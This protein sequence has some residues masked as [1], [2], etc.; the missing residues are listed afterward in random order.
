[1][2]E[3]VIPEFDKAAFNCPRCGAF[4]NQEWFLALAIDK[5]KAEYQNVT[6][7]M[8]TIDEYA[9]SKCVHCQKVSIWNR[10]KSS[11][12]YPKSNNRVFDL[13]EV[14]KDLSEDY[15]EACLVLG[16]SP[17]ASS[18]LS[19]RCLQALLREQGFSDKSLFKEIQLA[20]DSGKL[21]SHITESLDAIRNIG[22]FAAHPMKDTNSGEVLPVEPGEA[23]WNIETLEFLFD[24]FYVQ[25]AK[26]KKRKDAL[27]QK[28]KSIGKPEMK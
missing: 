28:L 9:F 3:Q 8:G 25:P 11:M 27:N 21:P 20:I 10:D 4:A 22:N 23:E 12:I 2:A 6:S 14:P 16:D 17:K 13:S 26:T 5:F 24:F 18:A 15:Q 1:M 19:R 7:Q